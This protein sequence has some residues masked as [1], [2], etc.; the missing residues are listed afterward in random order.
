MIE[1][2]KILKKMVSF[3]KDLLLF[4]EMR[5]PKNEMMGKV[6]IQNGENCSFSYFCSS[7]QCD[8]Q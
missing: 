1:D 4:L 2:N 6:S 5:K 8:L 7:Q 3:L